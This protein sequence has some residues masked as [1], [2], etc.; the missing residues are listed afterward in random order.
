MSTLFV[1]TTGGHLSE[2]HGFAERIPHQEAIWVT[3]RNEQSESLLAGRQVEY[4]PY[5]RTRNLADVLR[6]LPHADRVWRRFGIT[7]AVSTGS[8]IALGYLPYLAWRGVDCHYIESAARVAGPSLT[9][10]VIRRTPKVAVYSQYRHWA[11]GRWHFGGN[12][13]DDLEPI[14]GVRRGRDTL[15]VVVTV[16]TAAEFPFRRALE[17]LVPLLALDGPLRAATGSRIDVLWQTGC[18]PVSD[19]PIESVPYLP[20]PTLRAALSQADIVVCHAG[21]G[22]VTAAL[23]TG[24]TPLV[25]P[26]RRDR[27]EASDDHQ[28]E[29]AKELQ[30]RGLAVAREADAVT[31]DD[32]VTSLS[33]SVRPTP[34]RPEFGLIR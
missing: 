11:T 19:L 24:H 31:V 22:S 28:V 12:S 21:V 5:V 13:F 9:G 10:R 34:A 1:A 32:L 7:R 20:A 15:R 17:H 23:E 25:I 27:A 18:T 14:A 6:C 30:R 26:R 16:G 33:T 8:G 2:L 29:L 3:H 4:V